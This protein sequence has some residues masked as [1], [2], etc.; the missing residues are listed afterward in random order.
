MR[1]SVE[2]AV[3]SLAQSSHVDVSF[4]GRSIGRHLEK[5]GVGR[6]GCRR[7]K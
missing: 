1:S 2:E 7:G 3:D 4:P 6:T 5:L